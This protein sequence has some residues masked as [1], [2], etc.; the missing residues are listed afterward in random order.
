MGSDAGLVAVPG[1]SNPALWGSGGGDGAGTK[2]VEGRLCRRCA[3]AVPRQD[4]A[5]GA[6]RPSQPGSAQANRKASGEQPLGLLF[7]VVPLRSVPGFFFNTVLLGAGFLSRVPRISPPEQRAGTL[8][9][10][11]SPPR[12]AN[13]S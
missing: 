9:P 10:V 3:G 7:I 5:G 12:R 1:G 13:F 8:P 2:R 11:Y 6:R 4:G